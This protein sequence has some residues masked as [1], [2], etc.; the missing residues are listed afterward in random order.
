[1]REETGLTLEEKNC[2][3]LWFRQAI[4]QVELEQ[5]QANML[6]LYPPER[7]AAHRVFPARKRPLRG[8]QPT[9]NKEFA[10]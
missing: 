7:G 2:L 9:H 4:A 5:A 6:K 10:Y 8:A 1:M 3:R